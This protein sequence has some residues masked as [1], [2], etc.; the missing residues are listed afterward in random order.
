MRT[1]EAEWEGKVPTLYPTRRSMA[2]KSHS[3]SVLFVIFV[4]S[5]S[6]CSSPFLSAFICVHLRFHLINQPLHRGGEL[7]TE[8][9]AEE[10][11]RHFIAPLPE[12]RFGE[13]VA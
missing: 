5:C 3:L 10:G 7:L 4:S 13:E 9:G 8:S 11:Y 2:P 6:S 1:E 12:L